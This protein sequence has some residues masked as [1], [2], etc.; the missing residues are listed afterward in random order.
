[1][2]LFPAEVSGG[3]GFLEGD[4]RTA[5]PQARFCPTG[6]I[7]EATAASYLALPNV[8]CVGGTWLTPRRRAARRRLG[9]DHP[10]GE[11]LDVPR[12]LT[13]RRTSPQEGPT[14][15]PC[16]VPDL[17]GLPAPSSA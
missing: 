8:G 13:I 14:V 5:C 11:R 15:V 9:A 17:Y 12:H 10:A 1:M 3:V 2:K 6:G 7:T 4:R 16:L